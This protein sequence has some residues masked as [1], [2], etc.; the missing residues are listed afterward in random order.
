MLGLVASSH[1]D[2]AIQDMRDAISDPQHPITRD[3]LR[4]LA[5]LEIESDPQYKLPDTPH[6]SQ[7]W[8]EALQKKTA[9]FNTFVTQ[10]MTEL[11]A[12]V[13]RKT[14]DAYKISMDTLNSQHGATGQ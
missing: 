8:Q 5:L 13:S 11:Q 1:R 12:A 14:G 2:L 7:A 6:D 9:A 4:T 10:H 3:F